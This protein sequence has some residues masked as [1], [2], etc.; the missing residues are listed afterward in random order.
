MV[1]TSSELPVKTGDRTPG[2]TAFVP[3]SAGL[4]I[5]SYIISFFKNN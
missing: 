4:L 5:G 3:S 1:C 2:S